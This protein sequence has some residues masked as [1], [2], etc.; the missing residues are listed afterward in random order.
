[1]EPRTLLAFVP[2]GP[3][4][5][6]NTV[7]DAYQY[8]PAVASDA[9]G[10]FVVAWTTTPDPD[11]NEADVYAQ[12][13][14]AA[15][16]P[17]G[18]EI[19]VNDAS[20]GTGRGADVTMDADGDFIV[21]WT[22]YDDSGFGVFARRYSAAGV[23]RGD[24]FRV[25]TFTEDHQVGPVVASDAE[26]DFVVVWDAAHG[27]DRFGIYAQRYNSAGVPQGGEF[28]VGPPG[29]FQS[30]SRVAMD[31]DG[32]FVIAWD[33]QEGVR[34]QRYD[35]AGVPQGDE[36]VVA[37]GSP[38]YGFDL[39]SDA[40]GDF[41]VVLQ[42]FD[43][44]HL[45][46][47]LYS[48]AGV[49]QGGEFRIESNTPG[50]ESYPSVAMDAAGGF[51][52][53]WDEFVADAPFQFRGGV[54]GRRYSAAGVPEGDQ[55]EVRPFS[56]NDGGAYSAVASDAGGR[57][58]V[59]WQAW[60]DSGSGIFARRYGPT[61]LPTPVQVTRVYVNG[62]GLTG[63]T[64]LRGFRKLA[65]IDDV[66][67]YAVPAGTD[68]L[69]SI[70]WTGGIDRIAIRFDQDVRGSLQQGDLVVRGINRA[71]YPISDFHYDPVAGTAV[72]TLSAPVTNDRLTL[73]LDD[74]GIADLDGE[75][76]N[77]SDAYPSGDGTAG[78]DLDFGVNVLSGDANRDGRV[79]ALDLA[80]IRSKLNLST[81]NQR[82][83]NGVY[84]AFADLNADTFINALDLGAA[85]Q[86][87]NSRL[88]TG[89]PTTAAL[90]FGDRVFKRRTE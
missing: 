6:V 89:E 64:S 58:V 69:K 43:D 31:A 70:P 29:L 77:G 79:N 22:G 51:V 18:G 5:R 87:L 67:G 52:V 20:P 48:A 25:N 78:G 73:V 88:P 84:S 37:A 49:P 54:A 38:S 65:G 28:R 33:S 62:P 39:A 3:E 63:Q 32:D 21:A 72:W 50:N 76:A 16:V 42:N 86:R 1:L 80:F 41:V 4:F 15:G 36:L 30:N 24:E 14:D 40:G 13:Y 2:L 46:A 74:A 8:D 57:V 83:G 34:A 85:K 12:R 55:F 53:T 47:R 45:Y 81:D 66:Y 60:D 27:V 90:L 17:Q 26:G 82:V 68:Q 75:W 9:N 35:A 23:P 44:N 56:E 11:S 71:E 7:T 10:D 61:P 59:A 19:H